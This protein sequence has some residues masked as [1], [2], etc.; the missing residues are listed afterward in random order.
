M[1]NF[2]KKRVFHGKVKTPEGYH[3]RKTN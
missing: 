2:G 1:L 3:V